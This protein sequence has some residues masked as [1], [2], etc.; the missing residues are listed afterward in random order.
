MLVWHRVSTTRSFGPPTP[1]PVA[2]VDAAKDSSA[3]T[4]HGK[5]EKTKVVARRGEKAK[6]RTRT[7]G[8]ATR[9]AKAMRAP[10]QRKRCPRSEADECLSGFAGESR[11]G[12]R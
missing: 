11:A 4:A 5:V 1:A 7:L 2:E 10:R 9:Q 12:A 6:E 8:R 3:A